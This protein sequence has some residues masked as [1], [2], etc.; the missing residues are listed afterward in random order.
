MSDSLVRNP[1]VAGS[2]YPNDPVELTKLIT[3]LFA[4]SSKSEVS[5]NILG[6]V[7]PHAGYVYS[8]HVAAAG[9]KL[10]EGNKYDIIVVISP[11]HRVCFDGVSVFPGNAYRTPLGSVE[12]AVD[13][14]EDIVEES[15][16]VFKDNIGHSVNNTGGEH[17][18]EVQLPFLQIALQEFKLL[19]LVMGD[20]KYEICNSLADDLFRILKDKNA[21]IIASTDLSHFHTSQQAADLDGIFIREFNANNPLNLANCLNSRKCEACGG[22]PV[23]AMMLYSQRRGES[24]TVT[25]KYADS[26]AI[27]GDYS[28]VVGYFSGAVTI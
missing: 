18:L 24:K 21:L 26:A 28:S 8:G 16:V 15:G 11:S 2:F 5:G 20:Q 12:I 1:A 23:I 17:A 19:P 27:S 14:V 13:L 25:L 3:A 22:G 6:L 10:L 9:Y 7:S 4:D